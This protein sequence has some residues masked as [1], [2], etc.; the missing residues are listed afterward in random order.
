MQEQP[1][2][3]PGRMLL[4][5]LLVIGIVLGVVFVGGSIILTDTAVAQTAHHC[6]LLV[7]LW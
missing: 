6:G 5:S 1:I 7:Y 2:I 4:L 3:Q